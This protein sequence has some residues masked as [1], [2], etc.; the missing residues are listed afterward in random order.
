[1]LQV[2]LGPQPRLLASLALLVTARR[3]RIEA[4]DFVADR[5]GADLVLTVSGPAR[6]HET[7]VHR[8]RGLVGV[9]RVDAM[10]P[11]L[12]R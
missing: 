5:E 10:R 12:D 11:E 7:L 3:H 9:V 4:L 6:L 8:V 2:R 1:M